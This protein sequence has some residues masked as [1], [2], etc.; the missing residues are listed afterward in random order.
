MRVLFDIVHPAHVHFFKHMIRGLEQRGHQTRVVAR[1][2]DVTASL[3]DQLGI[4]YRSVG[5]PARGR[6]GQLRE[7]VTRDIALVR[8]IRDFGADAVVTRNPAGVHAARLTR[9]IGV[10]DSDDGPA[11]G[12]HFAAA[13]PF[14]HVLTSPDCVAE[15]WSRRHVKYRGYKQSAYL[16]PDHFTP[17]PGVLAEHGLSAGEP[18]FLVRF[19]AM[20]ASHDGG[21]AGLSLEL[22][23]EVIARLQQH[24]RVIVSSEGPIADEWKHLAFAVPPHRMLDL[25]AFAS[26]V[27]GDSQT[28]AAEAAVLGTPSLRLSTWAGR[29]SYLDELEHRYG[30]TFGYHPRDAAAF[31]TKLDELLAERKGSVRSGHQRMLAEK[32]NVAAWYTDFIE[33]LGRQG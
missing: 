16:H 24:G 14:A 29:L 4:A 26:L 18:F 13:R 12:V 6:F 25:I 9:T 23:R 33:S 8:E 21:E 19:V 15:Q 3:L 10:F 31:M 30:L 27:V 5:Q 1:A 11:A 20:I 28:M 2:K 17:D 7:L 32:V 22:K